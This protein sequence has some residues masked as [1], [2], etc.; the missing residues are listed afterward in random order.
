[1]S[2]FPKSCLLWNRVICAEMVSMLKT[3]PSQLAEAVAAGDPAG[4]V[5]AR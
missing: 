1:M 3:T 4:T 5:P 2:A